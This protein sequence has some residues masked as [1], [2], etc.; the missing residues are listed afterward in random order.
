MSWLTSAKK[1][2]LHL[3]DGAPSLEGIYVGSKAGHYRLLN[4]GIIEAE[5]ETVKM[6]GEAWVPRDRVLLMQVLS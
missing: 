6:D 3:L 1:V 5:G 2:R 4:V